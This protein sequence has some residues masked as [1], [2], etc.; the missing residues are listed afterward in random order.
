MP[1][2]SWAARSPSS[3]GSGST[4]QTCTTAAPTNSSGSGSCTINNV[5]QTVGPVP[6]TVTFASDGYYQSATATGSVNVGPVQTGTTLT[7]SPAT[8]DYADATNVSATLID[9]YTS[10]GA[11]DEPVTIT[12][13]GTQSCTGTTNASGVATCSI[14][15]NEP[16]GTY[17]L[18]ASFAGDA[19]VLP[20]LLT[21]TGTGT[22]VVTHEEA[23]LTYTGATTATNGSSATLSG[24]LTTDTT[25]LAGRTVTFTLGSGT[26][27]QSCSGT[28]NSSGAASCVIAKVNRPP[29]PFR[30]PRSS[31]ATPTT[32]RRPRRGAS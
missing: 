9:N 19:T 28:T 27:A 15:P 11:A 17:S 6:V 14:T 22:F 1:A 30:S 3:S 16:A 8:G 4:A 2:P 24:V 25:P 29:A 21:S 26:S 5:N 10:A 18:S 13:D 7:V 31:P 12:L 23:A 32:S 20:H